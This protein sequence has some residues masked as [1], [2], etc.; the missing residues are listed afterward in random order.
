LIQA[1]ASARDAASRSAGLLGDA[2]RGKE[3]AEAKAGSLS[4]EIA[5]HKGEADKALKE[6]EEQG[7]RRR[8]AEKKV[9]EGAQ[10]V[11]RLK[12]EIASGKVM[13]FLMFSP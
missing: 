10:E 7:R 5:V 3:E 9:E 6:A 11:T 2:V 4:V 8:E 13:V 12:A 1:R